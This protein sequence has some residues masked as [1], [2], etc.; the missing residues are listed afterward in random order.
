MLVLASK[1]PRRK[2]LL[3]RMG[4][5][6]AVAEA[7]IEE[8]ETGEPRDVVT[9]NAL[10]K[11]LKVRALYPDA[12]VLGADTVVAVDGEVFGKPAGEADAR[13]MLFALSGR[14]HEVYTGVALLAG[15]RHL[16]G[17]DVT[18][19]HFVPLR[20]EDVGAYIRSGEPFD[21]AGAYAIQGRAGMLID[22]IEGS[23]S[24]VVGL[25]QAMVRD[26]LIQAGLDF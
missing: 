17:C 2:E 1:S 25:P 26:F 14:W 11:A 9:G 13:R 24:N 6:F 21:K 3:E 10:R 18:R 15:D 16:T 12:P 23:F 19:V 5:T 4:L 20:E 22:R 7:D 8:T